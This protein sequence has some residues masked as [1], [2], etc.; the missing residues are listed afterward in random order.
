MEQI[1]QKFNFRN[2]IELRLTGDTYLSIE[3]TNDAAEKIEIHYDNEHVTAHVSEN[4][5]EIIDDTKKSL[6]KEDFPRFTSAINK[7][8]SLPKILRG[9]ISDALDI[10][11]EKTNKKSKETKITI[12]LLDNKHRKLKINSENLN[13]QISN[14]E[15][16]MIEIISGNLKITQDKKVSTQGTKITSANMTGRIAY[17]TKSRKITLEAGNGKVEITK[18]PNFNGA[19]EIHGN[20][21]KT[22]GIPSTENHQDGLCKINM[23]NGKINIS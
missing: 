2:H 10:K 3:K 11:R 17:G 5:V 7:K 21:I 12:H 4:L 8:D 9:L 20:N 18:E 14:L 6:S 15:L 1:N 16:G 23:N 19:F 13:A 22:T